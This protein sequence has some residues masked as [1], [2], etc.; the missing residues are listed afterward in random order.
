MEIKDLRETINY[1]NF[2]PFKEGLFCTIIFG[3]IENNQCSCKLYKKIRL[4]NKNIIVICPK[5]KVQ[6][7]ESNIRRYRMGYCGKIREIKT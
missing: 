1:K 6:I 4:Y 2:K 5:C 3:P 7:T